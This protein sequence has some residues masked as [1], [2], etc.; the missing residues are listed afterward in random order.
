VFS[1][2]DVLMPKIANV[3]VLASPSDTAKVLA[4]LG[5]DD[6]LVVIGETKAGYVN[7]Q[8]ATATGWVKVALVARR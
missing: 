8:G 3:R 6:E 7:V 5:R 4:T 2:G 1:E